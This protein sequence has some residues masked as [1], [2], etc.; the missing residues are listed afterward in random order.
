MK[1]CQLYQFKR[2]N[3]NLYLLREKAPF[4]DMVEQ[5]FQFQVKISK[6][7]MEFSQFLIEK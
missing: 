4:V 2:E 5:I 3:I 6:L 1:F 7:Q